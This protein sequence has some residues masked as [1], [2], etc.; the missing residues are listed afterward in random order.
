MITIIHGDDIAASRSFFLEQKEKDKNFVSLT[1]AF[2]ISD[3]A[4]NLEGSSLFFETKT[5]VVEDFFARV[6]KKSKDVKEIADFINKH[7]KKVNLI[8]WEG[9]ELGKKDTSLFT[10]A[11]VKQF[12]LPKALFSFLDNLSPGNGKNSIQLFHQVLETTPL[13][14]IIF[15]M[16]RQFRLLLA[17]S[18]SHS[19]ENIEEV[20]RMAFWQREK[21]ERQSS[22]FSSAKLK[23]I[24]RKLFEIEV[25]QR[26]GNLHLSL[27]Q[28]I[29]F[30]LLEI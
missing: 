11:I 18:D 14:L 30:F 20:I 1:G 16:Q 4:Q 3:L 9:K 13:E 6:K 2:T 7:D 25:F 24:Y 26:T 23:E 27:T 12:K 19:E 15:M 28:S 21:L 8:F 17:I 10:S 5:I 29:D 22:R